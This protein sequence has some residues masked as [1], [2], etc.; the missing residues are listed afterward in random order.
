MQS[1]TP[2]ALGNKGSV[3]VETKLSHVP[4][5]AILHSL[6]LRA[7]SLEDGKVLRPQGF[8]E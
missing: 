1:R 6:Q 4:E 8:K 7:Q 3:Q 5:V 2:S